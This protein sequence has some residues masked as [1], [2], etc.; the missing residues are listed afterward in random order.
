MRKVFFVCVRFGVCSLFTLSNLQPI[1]VHSAE[2]S[3]DWLPLPVYAV[4]CDGLFSSNPPLLCLS[5]NRL[6]SSNPHPSSLH[7]LR[8]F[9][10]LAIS[11]FSLRP[12]IL[13][14]S[15]SQTTSDVVA[16]SQMAFVLEELSQIRSLDVYGQFW[17]FLNMF[18]N[19]YR[20]GLK[21]ILLI[22]PN[23]G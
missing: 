17:C 8:V 18:T 1:M 23:A 11:L 5:L 9:S 3:G 6:Y 15:L 19:V 12:L 14:L 20:Q 10:C 13:E 2:R 7:P 21:L 4:D 22:T 16:C